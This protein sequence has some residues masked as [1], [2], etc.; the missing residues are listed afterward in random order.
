MS[1]IHVHRDHQLGLPRAREIAFS[2][3]EELEQ[4]FGMDCTIHEGEDSD[5]VEFTRAGGI[6]G[7]L[8]VTA[9]S[10]ELEARLGMLFSAFKGDVQ[11]KVEQTLDALLAKEG[12]VSGAAAKP[13]PAEA[14]KP[15]R[16]R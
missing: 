4:R 16:R 13:A 10:F 8:E 6:S 1:D 5:T 11:R 2:W 14:G 7:T 15:R 9:D 3:A 12:G